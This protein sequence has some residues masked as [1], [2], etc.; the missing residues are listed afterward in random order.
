MKQ[1]KDLGSSEAEI[2]LRRNVLGYAHRSHH[3]KVDESSPDPVRASMQSG[4]AQHGDGRHW[5]RP[6]VIVCRHQ[7]SMSAT[8]GKPSMPR[9]RRDDQMNV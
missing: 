4:R 2:F 3:C 7:L 6:A 8:R 5:K 9:Q 1:N